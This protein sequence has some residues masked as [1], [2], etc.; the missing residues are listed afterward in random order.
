MY[1]KRIE[2]HGFKSFADPVVI[3]FDQGITCVVGPNGSGKSNISDAIRWVLG[4]QSPKTLR[5]GKMEDIIFAG[6]Q[7]RKSRG[8][9][10]VTLV[11]DNTTSILPV[12]FSE[13]A[14]TRRLFRSGESEYEINNSPCRMRDIRDMIMDTGIGVDGYSLIGQGK[15]SEIISNKTESIRE[16]FEET[17]GIVS[18]RTR[19]KEAERKLEKSSENLD[20]VCDIIGEIEGRIDGLREDS[21]RAQEYLKLNNRYEELEVNIILRNIEK[22]ADKVKTLRDDVVGLAK[23]IS[24]NNSLIEKLEERLSQAKDKRRQLEVD[25]RL[26]REEVLEITTAMAEMEKDE[27]LSDAKKESLTQSVERLNAEISSLDGKISNGQEEIRS[28]ET[29][30]AELA[31]RLAVKRDAL[32]RV[33]EEQSGKEAGIKELSEDINSRRAEAFSISL[34]MT[35]LEEE[36]AAVANNIHTLKDRRTDMEDDKKDDAGIR[37]QIIED[38]R[39][40]EERANEIEKE[41]RLIKEAI[42][43]AYEEAKEAERARKDNFSRLERQKVQLGEARSRRATL[44]ELENSYEGYQAGVRHVMQ[45]QLPGIEGVVAELI[46]V[47]TGMEVAIET[48]LGGGM[49]NIV[50]TTD[51][52]AKNAIGQL[53]SKSAGRATFLPIES[54][55]PRQRAYEPAVEDMIGFVDYALDAISFDERHRKAME[56]LLSNILIFNNL[57]NAME[58]SKALRKAFRIVTLEGEVINASGAVTGGHYRNKRANIFERK[59]DIDSL[60]NIIEN[61]LNDIEKTEA[62]A[63]KASSQE[64]MFREEAQLKTDQLG[65]LREEQTEVRERL[66]SAKTKLDTMSQGD[67]KRASQLSNIIR[68]EDQLGEEIKTIRRK[69]A[70]KKTALAGLE[71]EIAGLEEILAKETDDASD[72]SEDIT[73]LKV[74]LESLLGQ[75]NSKQEKISSKKQ[76]LGED[77]RQKE[78][79]ELELDQVLQDID[80]LSS[81]T[82][83][84]KYET[85]RSRKQD[86]EQLLQEV[87]EK[88]EECDAAIDES[89]REEDRARQD[90]QALQQQKHDLEIKIT[91][92]DS[93]LD[94]LKDRLWEEFEISY[95][96][97]LDMRA[98]E[99][100][101]SK[102]TQENRKIKARLRELGDVNIGAIEEYEEV[103][104]RY[105]FLTAQRDDIQTSMGELDEIIHKLEKII[106]SKFKV[107]FKAIVENFK[108][109]F[110]E[111]F[112]GGQA[113]IVIEDEDNPL[114]SEISITAQPP[115]KQL[116]HINLLSGGEKTMTAIALMFS[117][118]KTK[119]T[120]CCVLDEVDAA[121][122]DSNIVIFADYL[123]KFTGTQFTMITHQKDMMEKADVMYGVTMP[124]HGVSKILSLNIG[125]IARAQELIDEGE[126]TGS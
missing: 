40:N 81:G 46:E 5:G 35:R 23:N 38:H 31:S 88:L 113:D 10:E 99:F 56:Y 66:T 90:L 50:C 106:R 83:F 21:Q 122:D 29:E 111:F 77:R 126:G 114:E 79:K 92:N 105:T 64:G 115:G 74:E 61:L 18:Y 32:A 96:E 27:E 104:K 116:T 108:T 13:V 52:A 59:S 43:E 53:K 6:T 95:A 57:D 97:A 118:L 124:E 119:P 125:D 34:E 15:I 62:M 4:E 47:P 117:V 94:N 93:K 55:R 7:N 58:A 73:A 2:I 37:D 67:E 51:A 28:L 19:K 121:L 86:L 69:H 101:I 89:D 71:K 123:K 100:A 107:S 103:N 110:T 24:D 8:M 112:G 54:I 48:A 80:R 26:Y 76:D 36:E 68:Q 45:A 12:D 98:E 87:E 9:A 17:A 20:R 85:I 70:E 16:I 102:A 41:I 39:R 3:E 11:I 65:S 25:N 33:L 30:L 49:Q 91:K 14:I 120:P 82:D 78:A 22:S 84:G 109:T 63:Q 1:F 72:D 60:Q 42:K 75:E 44:E